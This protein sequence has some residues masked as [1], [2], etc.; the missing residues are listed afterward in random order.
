MPHSVIIHS[1]P[2]PHYLGLVDIFCQVIT[3]E[4]GSVSPA[5]LSNLREGTVL[6]IVLIHNICSIHMLHDCLLS[7]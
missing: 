4:N 1:F 2:M 7:V 5:P 6:L 3:M